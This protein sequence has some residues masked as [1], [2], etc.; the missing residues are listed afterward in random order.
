[1][2]CMLI[3][4]INLNMC[5]K[6]VVGS[7]S[8][9]LD[10]HCIFQLVLQ[11][12][13]ILY[14]HLCLYMYALTSCN[15]NLDWYLLFPYIYMC[16]NCAYYIFY[17]WAQILIVLSLISYWQLFFNWYLIQAYASFSL[18]FH[19]GGENSCFSFQSVLFTFGILLPLFMLKND[20][21]I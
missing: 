20:L 3:L 14:T 7:M 12:I 9:T 16:F 19:K 15:I 17:L 4:K 2:P 10:Y 6:W 18:V 1:M 13:S 11:L 8:Y 21:D 5:M